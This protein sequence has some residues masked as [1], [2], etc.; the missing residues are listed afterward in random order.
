M[1][2]G[3]RNKVVGAKKIGMF[4]K[5]STK[6]VGLALIAMLIPVALVITFSVNS[7]TSTL[8]GIYMA[9]AQNLAEEAVCGIDFAVELGEST[10]GN[11]AMDMAEEIAKSVDQI[12]QKAV[13]DENGEETGV[14]VDNLDYDALNPVLNG[15]AIE[16][17]EGSY[18]YMVDKSGTMLYH[19]TKD[20]VGNSVENAAVKGIVSDLAAGKKVENGYAIYEYKGAMKLAGYAF[21][22]NG[23]IVI[24][25]ADYDAFMRIDYDTLI[26][27]I[28]IEGVEGSYAYMV[29]GDGTMLYHSNTEK[30]G[31]PVENAAVKGIVADLEAGK[32]VENGAVIYEYKGEDKLAGYAFTSQGNI[33]VV[34]ADYKTFIQPIKK[35]QMSLWEIGI[36]M[37]VI[38]GVAGAVVL[39]NMMK[40]LASVIPGIQNI[41]AFQLVRDKKNEKLC[42]RKDEIGLIAR[43]INAMQGNLK[44]IVNDISNA[45]QNIDANVE[46]LNEI[47]N[48]VNTMCSEN[49][50]TT[51][52]LAA[53]MEETSA[54]TISISDNI[55]EMKDGAKEI[56][57][58][59]VEGAS[60]S[61]EIMERATK[62]RK[63]TEIA[64]DN[65]M[66]LYDSVKERTE[67]AMEA[68]QA[69]NKIN[70][71]TETVM[72]ISSQTS[73]LALNASI[74][75]A[76]A[77]EA[78][79]GF[80][81]VATEIG[82]LAVQTK[83]AVTN[84][85][86]IVGEVNIAVENMT[87]CMEDTIGFLEDTVLKDYD[88]FSSVSVQYQQ[89][90][91]SFKAYMDGIK[92]GITDLN[93]TLMMVMDAINDI[94]DTMSDA[95]NG[96]SNI[97]G[98]TSDMVIATQ[99]T[100]SKAND[101]KNQVEDL[102]AIVDKFSLD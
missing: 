84:I 93:S 39:S 55:G 15:V 32:T 85:N 25:T 48:R 62:L 97:A 26:G 7:T 67:V 70:E 3:R 72:T 31:Q 80:A 56:E 8:K 59:T 100:K 91:D 35:Q 57:L 71:L 68:A 11:Y 73:L 12:P 99:N 23:D 28:T 24:V 50:E 61:E 20:K 40:A 65:T 53:G 19:P 79:R 17:V 46:E 77:G 86:Q 6:I 92:S 21:T 2:E 66:H 89:D 30:I 94:S 82:N 45:T 81:V 101:C 74:E 43:E 33:I 96:V 52:S 60:K 1:N 63:T 69:V 44:Q 9:Y 14:S 27:K 54:S 102:N 78:G 76:R 49:A 37:M 75:A 88:N 95:A 87:G 38:F 98:K 13:L 36:L 41:A 18:A 51:E 83:N 29:S 42:T 10:Y 47:S 90:A 16:G 4:S 22:Q 5:M 34:T 58:M 64:T